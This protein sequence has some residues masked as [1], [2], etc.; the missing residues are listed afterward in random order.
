L[1]EQ[2][3]WLS[4]ALPVALLLTACVPSEQPAAL[5]A[6]NSF[7]AALRDRNSQA[8]CNLLSTRTLQAL[9]STSRQ[10]CGAALAALA[11]PTDPADSIEV[12][13]DNAQLRAPSGVVFLAKFRTGW[14]VTA[15]GCRPRPDLPYDC[16][17]EG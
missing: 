10:P 1:T 2:V 8:A 17:L 11:L 7:Q 13:G 9:E 3:R 12:W 15:A 5:S 14:K 16:D 6:G 4:P